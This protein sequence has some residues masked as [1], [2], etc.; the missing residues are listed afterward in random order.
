M[1]NRSAPACSVIPVLVCNDV[2]K[3]SDWLCAAFGFKERLRAGNG[4]AQLTIGDGAVFLTASRIGQ[5]FA[6]QDSAEFRPPLEGIVTS[7]IHV[8][9]D[10]VDAH[11]RHAAESG[12]R[13]LQ[14]PETHIF[15]ERQY[16][17]V[18]LDGHRWNFSQ[19]VADVDPR[20][21]GATIVE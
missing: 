4:H 20:D 17:A 19:S 12:A 10:D 18:D 11:H 6:A 2:G 8:R 13:I 15:G 3:A 5:G 1:N 14:P 7:T 21:W 9:V 16:T